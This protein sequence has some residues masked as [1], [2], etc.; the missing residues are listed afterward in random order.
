M[1]KVLPG[2]EGSRSQIMKR[3]LVVGGVIAV[4]VFAVYF[5]RVSAI[6]KAKNETAAKIKALESDIVIPVEV[7]P[8][9]R[10]TVERVLRYTGTVEADENVVVA[11]KMS[12]RIVAVKVEEGD[13]VAKDQVVAIVDPEVT[14]QKFE[15]HEVTAPIA[16]KV[17]QVFLDPGA[18][19]NPAVP[20]V[21]IMN[22]AKVKVTVGLLEKDYAAVGEGTPVRLEFDA[23]PGKT[24]AASITQRSPVV[25]RSTGTVRAEIE[26][27]NRDG[28]LK[29]GMFVRVQVVPEIHKDAVL[30]P[31][32][33]TIGEVLL[34]MGAPVETKVFVVSGDRAVERSVRL[35]LGNGTS[36]EVLEG[37]APGETVVI[38]GQNLLRDGTRVKVL[39]S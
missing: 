24:R 31:S 35:G 5:L 1:K 6:Q 27:D 33:A 36:C 11:S 30:M 28:A 20:I 2:S 4:V 15:P 8:V 26:L 14:G 34:G 37:L 32:E 9:T 16:G 17:S 38:V 19:I 3:V 10:G 23:F 25:D 12:G 18:F 7:A 13:G 22:D 21:E 39:G 29:P